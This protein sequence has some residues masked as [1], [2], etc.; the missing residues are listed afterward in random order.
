[1]KIL[2]TNNIT[3]PQLRNEFIPFL[4]IIDVIMFNSKEEIRRHLE[5]SFTLL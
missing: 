3:Y 4:S 5:S 1:M 2:K